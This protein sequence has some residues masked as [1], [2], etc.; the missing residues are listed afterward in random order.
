MFQFRVRS[1]IAKGTHA[2]YMLEDGFDIASNADFRN[3]CDNYASQYM[4][5]NDLTTL[6]VHFELL[7]SDGTLWETFE[8]F[9]SIGTF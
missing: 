6:D 9:Y 2:E 4:E 7:D 1:F 5:D 8:A 3:A